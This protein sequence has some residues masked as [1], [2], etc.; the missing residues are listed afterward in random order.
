[1]GKVVK[2]SDE[3]LEKAKKM[4]KEGYHI[5]Y[6]ALKLNRSYGSLYRRL[7]RKYKRH[8][9]TWTTEDKNKVLDLK[10]QGLSDSNIANLMGGHRVYVNHILNSCKK[11][12]GL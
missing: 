2:I 4:I 9:K 7:G 8:Y 1:M 10:N 11:K 12:I 5:T 6:I 3:E